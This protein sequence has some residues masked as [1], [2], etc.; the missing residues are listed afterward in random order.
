MYA[1]RQAYQGAK[2]AAVK[3]LMQIR[4]GIGELEAL[5]YVFLAQLRCATYRCTLSS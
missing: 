4:T 5:L 3:L 2:R 1:P